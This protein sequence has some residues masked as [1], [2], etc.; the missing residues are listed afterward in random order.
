M[1]T[2]PPSLPR[3]T[4]PL[5]RLSA[6]A[7]AADGLADRIPYSAVALLA[8]LS[9]ANIFWRSG[10]TKV[11]GFSVT[12]ATIF[13]FKEEYKV[14]LLPPE[15]AAY[16]A[17]LSEHLFSLLLVIGL[18]SRLSAAALMGMTLVIQ[19]F[20]YPDAWPTH[21]LWITAQVIVLARGPGV[22]SLDY[23]IERRFQGTL[24]ATS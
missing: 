9:I 5:A 8:R 12:D 22:L 10:Q 23:L 3:G 15:V 1:T 24:A 4:A 17:T 11:S 2:R 14:P 20:V 13:L 6:M 19:I 18:A 7:A 16:L 21:I